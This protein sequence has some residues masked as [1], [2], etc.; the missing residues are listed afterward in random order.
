LV[1]SG[2]LILLGNNSVLNRAADIN[3]AVTVLP[4]GV[5]QVTIP[6]VTIS[7][8]AAVTTVIFHIGAATGPFTIVNPTGTAATVTFNGNTYSVAAQSSLDLNGPASGDNSTL[9]LTPPT[10]PNTDSQAV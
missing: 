6:T 9:T 1:N 5:S 3:L 10:D 8:F 4:S 2:G 7:N